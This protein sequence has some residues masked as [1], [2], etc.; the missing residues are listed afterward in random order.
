[1]LCQQLLDQVQSLVR[2]DCNYSNLE[3]I[4]RESIWD[5]ESGCWKIPEPVIQKTHLP[6]GKG[7]GGCCGGQEG[8]AGM[9]LCYTQQVLLGLHTLISSYT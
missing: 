3:R 2:H 6:A 5:K 8:D 4:R 9:Q 1:M 7:R